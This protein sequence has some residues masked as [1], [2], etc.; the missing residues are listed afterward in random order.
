M[1]S[2]DKD[3]VYLLLQLLLTALVN[4]TVGAVL[5]IFTFALS[6]P[7]L[8]WSFAPS[9]PS[10]IAFFAV[11]VVAAVSMVAS[12]LALLYAAGTAVVVTT[13]SFASAQRHRLHDRQRPETLH[14]R[15]SHYE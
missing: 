8:L 1:N 13:A 4:Y 10:A 3:W 6:L 2:R 5:S 9:W 7:S 12:Y 11:A 14:Y 15:R